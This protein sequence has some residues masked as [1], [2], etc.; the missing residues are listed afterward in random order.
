[1]YLDLK[2]WVKTDISDK[3]YRER[4]QREALLKQQQSNEEQMT[5]E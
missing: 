1:M 4:I 5:G 3:E 2:E